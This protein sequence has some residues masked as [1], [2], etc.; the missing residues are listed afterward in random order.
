MKAK[1]YLFLMQKILQQVDEGVHVLDRN[2][3]TII[4]IMNQCPI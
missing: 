1:E 4:Y 3:N 2:G